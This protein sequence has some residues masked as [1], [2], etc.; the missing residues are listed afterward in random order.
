MS[1]VFNGAAAL[2]CDE[3][4]VGSEPD[5]LVLCILRFKQFDASSGIRMVSLHNRESGT[6]RRELYGILNSNGSISS[7]HYDGLGTSSAGPTSATSENQWYI[8]IF[9][10]EATNL[11]RVKLN[12]HSFQSNITNRL[13]SMGLNRTTFGSLAIGNPPTF[14]ANFNGK[15]AEIAIWSN[16]DSSVRDDIITDYLNNVS[17]NLIFPTYLRLYQSLRNDINIDHIG[18]D[19][20]N[21]NVTFD[22]ND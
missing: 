16:I 1:A 6:N 12:N 20:I 9:S 17:P 8:G 19:L 11:R 5:Y 4:V 22:S 7:V 10:F 14:I 18:P 21:E 2:Y 3:S 13:N 15:L